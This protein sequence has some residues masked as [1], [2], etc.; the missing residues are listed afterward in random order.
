MVGWMCRGGIWFIG[1]LNGWLDVQRNM[2]YGF[3]S[4]LFLVLLPDTYGYVPWLC[5][6]VCIL[7]VFFL[8][9]FSCFSSL[10][11]VLW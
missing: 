3:L 7:L 1:W 2:V 8:R 11:I 6:V 5:Y 9:S 10:F 4:L